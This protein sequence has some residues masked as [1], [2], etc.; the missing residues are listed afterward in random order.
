MP[1]SPG[2]KVNL[3]CSYNGCTQRN[4]DIEVSSFVDG[5]CDVF[6]QPVPN[7]K[8]FNVECNDCH[9]KYSVWIVPAEGTRFKGNVVD[10]VRFE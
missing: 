5:P 6:C 8:K 3:I 1:V 2:E 10:V 9:C 7:S 4:F